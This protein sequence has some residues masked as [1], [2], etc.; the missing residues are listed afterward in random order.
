[1]CYFVYQKQPACLKTNGQH[2]SNIST[3]VLA[4]IPV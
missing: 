2:S 1:M 3:E 4:I